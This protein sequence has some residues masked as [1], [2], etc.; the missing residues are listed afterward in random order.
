LKGEYIELYKFNLRDYLE[1]DYKYGNFFASKSKDSKFTKNF[2]CTK[3]TKSGR[4]TII[5]N[6]FKK[7]KNG[8]IKSKKISDLKREKLLKRVFQIEAI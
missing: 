5:D 8:S 6:E 2:I 1:V 4:V 3:P 7:F